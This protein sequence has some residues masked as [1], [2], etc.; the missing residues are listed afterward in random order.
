MANVEPAERRRFQRFRFDSVLH[1]RQG[2]GLQECVLL[3][4]SFRGFLARCPRDWLPQ[5]GERLEV[6]WQLAKMI[7]LE[8]DAVVVHAGADRI[9]CTWEA[10]DTESFA[11]LKRLVEMNLADHRLV[12]RELEYLKDEPVRRFPESLH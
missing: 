5:S 4:M 10:R 1:V 8:L 7:R 11:H 3:D 6:E 2:D 9:G 12:A